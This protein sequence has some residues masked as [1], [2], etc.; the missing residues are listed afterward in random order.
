MTGARSTTVAGL[1]D[2]LWQAE[3]ERVTVDPLTADDPGLTIEDAYAIQTHNI[4]R[5]VAAGS[6]VRGHKVGLTSRPVQQ[7]LGVAEPN[8]GVLLDDMFVDEADEVRFDT[9]IQP[10]VESEIA[11]LMASD[12]AGPGVTTTDALAAVAGVLGAVEIVDSRIADWRIRIA[13]TV[14]DNASSGRAV[15]GARMV[16]VT[17]VDLRLVGVLFSRN[18]VPIESGAGAAVLGN[19]AR[20]VAWL[21]NKLGALGSGLRRGDI[22]LSGALHRMVPVRAGDLFQARFAHLGD[23]T[24]QFSGGQP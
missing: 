14:A 21:A 8:F 6:V 2:R 10:R 15:V 7:L 16:P 13:D 23:V 20:C 19:P 9:L 17:A 1:A 22:V 3:S 12:L 4:D 5:R 18:G 11:F 24:V